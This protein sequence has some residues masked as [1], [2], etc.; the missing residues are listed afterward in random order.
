MDVIKLVW[1]SGGVRRDKRYKGE[2]Y[3][4]QRALFGRE[5][6]VRQIVWGIMSVVCECE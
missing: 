6:D 4:R 1:I 3:G 2:P 5:V